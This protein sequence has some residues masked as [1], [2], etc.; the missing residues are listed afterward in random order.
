MSSFVAAG[1]AYSS[2]NINMIPFF[3]FYSMFGLQRIGDLAWAAGDMRARGF[4]MGGTS[5][6]TTLAGEGLQHQDGHSHL[7]SYPYPTIKSY[8][9]AFSYELAVIIQDG[10]KRM[11]VDQ[12]SIFYYITIMNELYP[13][14]PM[15]KGVKEGIIKGMYK[16][17]ESA[18]KNAKN[19]VNLFGSGTI[20]N[21]VIEAQKLL[22]EKYD[23]SAD[24]WSI[25][26]Y[27]ELHYNAIMTERWNMFHP[28]KKAQLPYVSQQLKGSTGVFV[29]A[30]DYVKALPESIAR[31]IPGRLVSL[32]TD[33][34]GRSDGRRHLR[35]FFEVDARYITLAAL[36][37]LLQEG[38]LKAADL[39]KALKDLEIDP[40]KA[41]PMIS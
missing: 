20:L 39:K 30:S 1:T 8:D 9:P 11:Y 35:D 23:I 26:S 34:F 10:I 6:R 16:F 27:K 24:I 19:S 13:Q 17:R 22:Q 25:T 29:A 12:E 18:N 40:E 33:G 2:H 5:G 14:P 7:L 38:K 37:G 41:N 4:L 28:D 36:Y 3:T 15:P 21:K 31:W 32:G